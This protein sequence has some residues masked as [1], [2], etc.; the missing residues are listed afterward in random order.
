MRLLVLQ[1]K[2]APIFFNVPAA[3]D[4]LAKEGEVYTLRRRR[5]TVGE[6]M[7]REGDLFRFKELGRVSIEEVKEISSCDEGELGE[8]LGKSGFRSVESWCAA[9]AAG[10]S[11]LY[12]VVRKK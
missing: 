7:A 6:T 5:K 3:R 2:V 1:Q 12:R 4:Q 9:R 8:Y 11:V 10:A